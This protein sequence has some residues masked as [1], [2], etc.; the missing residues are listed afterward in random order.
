MRERNNSGFTLIEMLVVIFIICLLAVGIML[1]IGDARSKARD[2][3][4]R[5]D[6]Q[7]VSTALGLYFD[8]HDNTYPNSGVNGVWRGTCSDYGSYGTSG[9]AGWVPNLAPTYM[10]LLPVDPKP[11]EP[12]G[13][14]LYISNGVD[15]KLLAYSTVESR[16]F[17]HDELYELGRPFTYSVNTP[18]AADW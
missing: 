2:T 3:K 16:V 12:Y 8:E 14:Y 1:S 17:S 7:Q 5:V 10:P 11:I 4:R 15:Y 18:G 13:C 9:L 6:L